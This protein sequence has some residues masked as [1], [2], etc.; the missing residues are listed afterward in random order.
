MINTVEKLKELRPD[1]VSEFEA[2]S[3]KELLNQIYLEVIDGLN[4][5]ERVQIFMNECTTLSKTTYT[6]EV[7]KG[8]IQSKQ[9]ADISDFC[10]MALEDTEDMDLE[11]TRQYLREEVI[12]IKF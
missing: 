1:L 12:D 7:I 6:P 2:M 10:E 3:H 5:E 11:E 9:S 4:M 8:L